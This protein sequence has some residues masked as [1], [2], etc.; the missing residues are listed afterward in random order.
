MLARDELGHHTQI[1]FGLLVQIP[2]GKVGIEKRSIEL[3]RRPER[4]SMRTDVASS[5]GIARSWS[6]GVLRDAPRSVSTHDVG[7]MAFDLQ[8]AVL[9]SEGLVS[10]GIGSAFAF[11]FF[12]FFLAMALDRSMNVKEKQLARSKT[13]RGAAQAGSDR[14]AMFAGGYGAGHQMRNSKLGDYPMPLALGVI[15]FLGM[16]RARSGMGQAGR[17]GMAALVG[18]GCYGAGKMGEKAGEKAKNDGN[19]FSWGKKK[20]TEKTSGLYTD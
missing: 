2:G 4:N 13:V 5:F 17:L 15:G 12:A 7:A 19:L 9:G 8:F 14:L 3:P 20:G 11:F 6:F 10:A 16:R 1:Q 18:A